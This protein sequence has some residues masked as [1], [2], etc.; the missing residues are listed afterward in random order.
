[1]A[2]KPIANH[3]KFVFQWQQ[4]L[5]YCLSSDTWTKRKGIRSYEL[6]SM[7]L[8]LIGISNIG[9]LWHDEDVKIIVSMREYFIK[10]SL[11]ALQTGHDIEM[12]ISWLCKPSSAPLR[13]ELLQPIENAFANRH[14]GY[15]E[16]RRLTTTLASYLVI[17]W[18]EHH[19]EIKRE[20]ENGKAFEKLL[21]IGVDM[22]E[23]LALELQARVATAPQ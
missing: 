2:V 6:S 14:D 21:H 22:H 11:L 5:D 7:W 1:L 15:S 9:D 10:A 13:L 4:M 12:L 23:P 19:Q 16:E 3:E 17:L 20:P 8:N 18:E